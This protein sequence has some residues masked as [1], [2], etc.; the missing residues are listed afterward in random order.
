MAL[1]NLLL[2]LVNHLISPNY[3]DQWSKWKRMECFIDVCIDNRSCMMD[4]SKYEFIT[5]ASNPMIVRWYT[6]LIG[7]S[8]TLEF[9]PGVK[10]DISNGMSSLCRHSIVDSP[11][12]YS[13]ENNLSAISKSSKANKTQ[14]SKIGEW[15][16]SKDGHFGFERT[17][18]RFEDSNDVWQFQRQHIR[19][20][21]DQCA[22]CQKMIMSPHGFAI[23]R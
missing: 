15:H 13:K 4:C 9:I 2:S 20:F 12:E 8:S 22:C 11:Q 23:L 10:N 3:V 6:A 16:N 19:Y 18:K 14:N 21:I 5:E 7:F 17:L 1:T